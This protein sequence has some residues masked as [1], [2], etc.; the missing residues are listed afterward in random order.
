MLEE[1][2]EPYSQGNDAGKLV[3]RLALGILLLLHG[4]AKLQTPEIFSAMEPTLTALQLPP[5]TAW[6]TLVGEVL[7]PI[8]LIAGVFSR[9]AGIMIALQMAAIMIV[10]YTSEL[11][12]FQPLGGYAL[13]LQ[14]IFLFT[15]IAI[16]CLGS[17]V[18]AL[19]RD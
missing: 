3:L 6:F 14:A 11:G 7:A 10:G 18:Y 5:Q 13:E 16:A 12:S 2:Q 9:V 4:M 1:F 19:V 8:L 15:G 17:G